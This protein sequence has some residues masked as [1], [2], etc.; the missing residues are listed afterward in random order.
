MFSFIHLFLGKLLNMSV[1]GGNILFLHKDLMSLLENLTY[2]RHS[3]TQL[4]FF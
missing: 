3:E 4:K 1:L 2:S